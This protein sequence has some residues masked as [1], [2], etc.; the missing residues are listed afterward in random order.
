MAALAVGGRSD[1]LEAPA[2]I[3]SAVSAGRITIAVA[4]G[5]DDVGDAHLPLE[6]HRAFA[7][8]QP[9]GANASVM[10]ENMASKAGT[11]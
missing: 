11:A 3:A 10:R 9:S 5:V 4:I 1:L 7:G 8:L 2:S 6:R